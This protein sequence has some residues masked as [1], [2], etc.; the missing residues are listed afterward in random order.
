M[1][2]TKEEIL[3]DLLWFYLH[4]MEV[5]GQEFCLVND[6]HKTSFVFRRNKNLWVWHDMK[7]SKSLWF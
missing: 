2:N 5:N 6:I 3:K 4:T 7:V 1:W